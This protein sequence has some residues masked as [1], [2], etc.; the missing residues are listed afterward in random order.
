MTA[1]HRG[2]ARAEVA[3]REAHGASWLTV[4]FVGGAE[5]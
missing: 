5:W 1:A 4:L 3:V 2:H